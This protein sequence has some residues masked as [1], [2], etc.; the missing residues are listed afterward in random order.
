MPFYGGLD[1]LKSH[2]KESASNEIK[3]KLS[4]ELIE[5]L[6]QQR[7]WKRNFGIDHVF[8][9]GKVSWDFRR[10]K[11]ATWGTQFLELDEMQNPIKLLLERHPW[12]SND[13]AVPYPTFFHPTSD[14]D[15]VAWQ[16]KIMQVSILTVLLDHQQISTLTVNFYDANTSH[17]SSKIRPMN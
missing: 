3:D 15:I 14:N 11:N 17:P 9:L 8:V 10:G 4:Q 2:F 1:I 7:F 13:V 5:W 12:H 16:T 6:E